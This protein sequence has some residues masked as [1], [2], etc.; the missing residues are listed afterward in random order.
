MSTFR[1]TNPVTGETETE[2]ATLTE[3]ELD[4]ALNRSAN[5]YEEWR[6]TPLKERTQ[7]LRNFADLIE[8][9]RDDLATVISRE[10]GK[11]VVDAKGELQYGIDIPIYYAD[12]A[13][14]FLGDE[15]RKSTSG[16]RA[17]VRKTPVGMLLGVM[18]WNYPY[19][20][21]VR[22]AAPNLAAGNV[23]LVKHAS[24]C[25]ESALLIEQLF[26]EAGL[27]EGAYINLFATHE[28]LE[29]VIAD[30]RLRGVSITGSERAGAAVASL[31]GK[32][33]KKVVLELGGSDPYLVLET[34]DLSDVAFQC[35]KARLSNAGQSC[36]GGKRFIVADHLYDDFVAEFTRTMAAMQPGDPTSNDAGYG[37]LV[38]KQA[39]DELSAQVQDALDKGAVAQTGGQPLDGP[40]AYFPPTVLTGVEPGMRA[41][42]EE[43]FGPVA[44]VHRVADIDAA[45]DMANDSPYGLGAAVF[46]NN[47]DVAVD[48]ANRLEA[49]MVWINE[50]EGGGAS[51]PF[52][53]T[54][55]SGF[56]RELGPEGFAEFLNRKLIHFPVQQ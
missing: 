53:G 2:F 38:S 54:K 30:P 4:D 27:P 22:F 1:V 43:L 18:P 13:E 5:A 48:V 3:A 44:V 21:V 20:Q 36:N 50:R 46:H 40:G 29:R 34:D 37:P 6:K 19:Y 8:E 11:R 26:R 42:H 56:G 16:G 45:V 23:I 28:Q 17:I 39:V 32:H 24:Q 10:M 31:A 49:G 25:P 51:L 7:V 35:T 12:H 15:V 41:Y 55:R 47:P 9:R 52:G 14:E 33:L